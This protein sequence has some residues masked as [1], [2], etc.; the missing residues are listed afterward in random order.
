MRSLCSG[1]LGYS[2]AT[3]LLEIFCNRMQSVARYFTSFAKYVSLN[4]NMFYPFVKYWQTNYIFLLM[5]RDKGV[6]IR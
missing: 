1:Q 2:H 6:R 4:K 5:F 3:N